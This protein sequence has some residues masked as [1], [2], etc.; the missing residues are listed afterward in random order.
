M[1]HQISSVVDFGNI[2]SKKTKFFCD[3]CNISGGSFYKMS[4]IELGAFSFDVKH[5]KEDG[6]IIAVDDVTPCNKVFI[7]SKLFCNGE[8]YQDKNLESKSSSKSSLSRTQNLGAIYIK[9]GAQ[10]VYDI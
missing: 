9:T 6:E 1:V 10:V 2:S 7:G 5:G 4:T 8:K 3:Y